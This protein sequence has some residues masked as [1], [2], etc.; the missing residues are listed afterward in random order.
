MARKHSRDDDPVKGW[1]F[2]GEIELDEQNIPRYY[3]SEPMLEIRDE[4][5][6]VKIL[7]EASGSR[8][9][10]VVVERIR[11]YSVDISLKY[12]GRHIKKRI[13]LPVRV[14][15]SGYSIKV[16]NGVAQIY[17]AKEST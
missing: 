14:R 15:V 2:W 5:D 3:L 16:K 17:L 13:E 4:G 11:P 12:K 10:D 7:V 9:E 6:S 1:R 8:E